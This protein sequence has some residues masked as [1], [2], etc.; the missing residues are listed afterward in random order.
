MQIRQVTKIQR[1]LAKVC[2][3]CPVFVRT[4]ER[5]KGFVCWFTKNIDSALCPFCRVCQ[6]V[7][8]QQYGR[9]IAADRV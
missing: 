5:Q 9:M 7:Y 3:I 6:K 1:L 2:T 8:G 4:G